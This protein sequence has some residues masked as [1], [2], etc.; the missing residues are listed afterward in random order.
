MVSEKL[1]AF[2]SEASRSEPES[3]CLPLSRFVGSRRAELVYQC[4]YTYPQR[5]LTDARMV[6]TLKYHDRLT[7]D[8]LKQIYLD[9]HG[10]SARSSGSKDHAN[11]QIDDIQQ[12][13]VTQSWSNGSGH[14]RS[15]ESGNHSWTA[16]A[17][18]QHA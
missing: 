8:D 2:E 4:N 11:V 18:L 13:R 10:E 17:E 14:Y 3:C 5:A 6:A 9:F 16:S 15:R 1:E 12:H 7:W